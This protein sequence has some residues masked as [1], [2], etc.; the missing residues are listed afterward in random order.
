[1]MAKILKKQNIKPDVILSSSAVRAYDYAKVIAEEFGIRK[2][3]IEVTKKLYMAD[4]EDMLDIIR[5]LK[6]SNQTVFLI[7]HN[8]DL[9]DFANSLTNERI[10]NIPTSGIF[11]V[12]FDAE[13]WKDADFGK[14][15]FISF[16]YPK[17]HY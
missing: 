13:S 1:M 9:T 16:D 5:S 17:K 4:E 14:G 7:G 6:K 15:K 3:Q 2:N 8:P 12:E 10:D 11:A